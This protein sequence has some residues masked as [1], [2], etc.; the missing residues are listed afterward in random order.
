MAIL[1]H[2]YA[3]LLM[4]LSLRKHLLFMLIVLGSI[5]TIAAV[6]PVNG[7]TRKNN[8]PSIP[9]VRF[10]E[11]TSHPKK[12]IN[13]LVRT[14]ANYIVWWESSYLYGDGCIDDDHKIHNGLDCRVDDEDCHERFSVEW[15]KLEP[16]MDLSPDGMTSRVKAVF[17]GRLVGPGGYGHLDGFKYEFRIQRVEKVTAIPRRVSWKKL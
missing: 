1:K 13:K 14:E 15:K 7:Q 10:C 12:Y 8:A 5:S 9:T 6:A 16:F 11:L 4:M 3:A 2:R 17:I